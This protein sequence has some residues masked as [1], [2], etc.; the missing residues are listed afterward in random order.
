MKVVG[1]C[2]LPNPYLLAL[3][4][5][6]LATVLW[7]REQGWMTPWGWVGVPMGQVEGDLWVMRPMIQ[8]AQ[9]HAGMM[10][11]GRRDPQA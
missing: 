1:W 11:W 3:D 2:A 9:S 8:S 5:S 4:Q 10:C 6:G 7:F